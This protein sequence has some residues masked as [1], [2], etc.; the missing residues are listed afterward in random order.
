MTLRLGHSGDVDDRADPGGRC[1]KRR[2]VREGCPYDFEG[3]SVNPLGLH[4][5]GTYDAT[6]AIPLLDEMFGKVAAD[7]TCGARQ[8]NDAIFSKS[9]SHLELRLTFEI[10]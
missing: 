4:R 3:E 2:S 1:V 5:F 9:L 7:E 6:H 10:V 8:E